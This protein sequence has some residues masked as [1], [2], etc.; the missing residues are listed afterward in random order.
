[1]NSPIVEASNM[2]DSDQCLPVS[3]AQ[4]GLESVLFKASCAR[5]TETVYE[6]SGTLVRS[7]Q[8]ASMIAKFE[9]FGRLTS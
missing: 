2:R 5:D 3:T 4:V 6:T 7:F 9:P 1:M 8:I